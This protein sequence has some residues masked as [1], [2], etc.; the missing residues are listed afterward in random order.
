M[1]SARRDLERNKDGWHKYYALLDCGTLRWFGDEASANKF[2]AAEQSALA[3]LEAEALRRERER[4]AT[5]GLERDAEAQTVAAQE[6]RAPHKDGKDQGDAKHLS[7][8]RG[9]IDLNAVGAR[10]ELTAPEGESVGP[11]L[12]AMRLQSSLSPQSSAPHTTLDFPLPPPSI[13]HALRLRRI[14]RAAGLGC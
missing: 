5:D 12:P 14:P 11:M 7:L 1:V 4:A 10:V 3:T 13:T 6:A 2:R 8:V 9:A